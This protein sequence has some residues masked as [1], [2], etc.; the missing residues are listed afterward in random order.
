MFDDQDRDSI[1]TQA[2]QQLPEGRFLLTPQAGRRFIEN[3][4]HWIGRQRAGDLQDALSSERQAAGL[5]M[6]A[7]G[8]TDARKLAHRLV[9][10]LLLLSAIQPQSGRQHAAAGP[11]IGAAGD[12]VQEAHFR[13]QLDVLESARHAQSSDVPLRRRADVATEELHLS[14]AHR[15]GSGDQVEHR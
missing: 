9:M 7:I 8:Q 10:D 5:L 14:G 15:Q 1:G 12:V 3:Q 11:G 6:G 2:T 13:P 4:Q